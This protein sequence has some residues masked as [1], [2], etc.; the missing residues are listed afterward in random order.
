MT[1]WVKMLAS[2][3]DSLGSLPG[4][5]IFPLFLS[6]PLSL[7]LSFSLFFSC[8]IHI[9]HLKN[10]KGKFIFFVNSIWCLERS[11]V[12]LCEF[13]QDLPCLGTQKLVFWTPTNFIPVGLCWG[14]MWY[15]RHSTVSLLNNNV[16][17]LLMRKDTNSRL[18]HHPQTNCN[19]S[20]CRTWNFLRISGNS[21]QRPEKQ[22]H[23]SLV[24]D[25][26]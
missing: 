17:W 26:R 22:P 16:F 23:Q 13:S 6:L 9:Y 11:L 4:T 5:H 8:N 21:E 14:Y 7:P 1:R 20:S 24:F 12:L 15:S 19:Q 18:Q 25:R 2:R 10:R 3:L